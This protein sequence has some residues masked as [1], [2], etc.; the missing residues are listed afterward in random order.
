MADTRTLPARRAAGV[1]V[2]LAI[3]CAFAVLPLLWGLSTSFKPEKSVLSTPAHWI[4]RV[5][6]FD[7][8]VKVLHSQIPLNLLNTVVVSVVTVL[9]TLLIAIPAA[10][11]AARFRFRGKT[12]LLFYILM[13][14][15]I[16]GIAILVPLYYLAVRV[17]VYDTY[18]VLIIIYTAWQVPTITWI[19]RGFFESIPAEIE[20]S[21]RV[22]GCSA[23]GAF[24]R[25]ILPLAKPGLGAASIICFVYVWNDYLI[26]STFV[27]NPRL[28]LVSVG[29]YGYLTQYGIVWGQLMAAVVLT[30]VP[31]ILAF[32][33]FERR[34]VA[35][36][37]AGASKG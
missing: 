5:L 22:D 26:A 3:A 34:L 31:M 4:P 16:P 13:T 29:L 30:L 10:Y 19:L 6:T 11:S 37:S 7:N 15:M 8:Y 17:H 9:V 36:L 33:V 1:Y 23:A 18:L 2:G 21:G 32:V 14:S 35:G 12:A 20:E 27:S 24:V 25:L 28:R